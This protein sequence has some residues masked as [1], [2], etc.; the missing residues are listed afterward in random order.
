MTTADGPDTDDTGSAGF[1]P[2]WLRRVTAAFPALGGALFVVAGALGSWGT[3]VLAR[4]MPGECGG[5]APPC[6][7]GSVSALFSLMG[8]V[9]L[10]LP[11]GIGLA[12]RRPGIAA[13]GGALVAGGMATGIFVSRFVA[14]PITSSTST[15][16]WFVAILGSIA[17]VCALVAL[18]TVARP[19][20]GA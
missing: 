15:T 13:T 14:D 17:L 2:A 6:P 3:F 1:F 18:V 5:D 20:R 12:R 16:W 7:P 10:L 11:L 8:A 19:V 9:F 4:G